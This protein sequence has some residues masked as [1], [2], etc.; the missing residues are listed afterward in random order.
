MVINSLFWFVLALIFAAIE[1]EAEGK[2]GWA[3]KAPTWYRTRGWAARLYGMVMS[4][5]PLT[6]YHLF[7]FFMPIMI[8]HSQFFLGVAWS[9]SRELLAWALYFAW[10]PIWDFVWFVLNPYYGIRNFKKDKV[11]WHSKSYWVFGLFPVDYLTGW[12]VS[13]GLALVAGCLAH[14]LQIFYAHLGMMGVFLLGVLVTIVV[15][16]P[17]YKHWYWKMRQSDDRDIAGIFH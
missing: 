15:V 1:C 3:E 6:G 9:P 4:G 10:C 13:A 5:K 11:W 2:D 17:V 7:M 8:F 14:R 12:V 16:A